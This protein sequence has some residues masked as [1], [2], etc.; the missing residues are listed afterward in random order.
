MANLRLLPSVQIISKR[1]V[2]SIFNRGR[3]PEQGRAQSCV[4]LGALWRNSLAPPNTSLPRALFFSPKPVAPW[5]L[6]DP[7]PTEAC[8]VKD[9]CDQIH[10]DTSPLQEVRQ[11]R[12]PS[13]FVSR[14]YL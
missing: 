1:V 2:K 7:L 6:P 9:D 5:S 8:G 12:V 10:K 13:L 4:I 11:G 3:I 14:W